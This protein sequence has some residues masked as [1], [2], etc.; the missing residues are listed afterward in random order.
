M[1]L[2]PGYGTKVCIRERSP[3]LGLTGGLLPEVCII[4]SGP[5]AARYAAAIAHAGWATPVVADSSATAVGLGMLAE[6][7]GLIA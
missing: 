6:G 7:L 5:L 4:G 1:V 2:L 3:T